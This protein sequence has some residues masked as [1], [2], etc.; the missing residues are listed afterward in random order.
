G[1]VARGEEIQLA[2]LPDHQCNEDRDA[3]DQ[4]RRLGVPLSI[5]IG[6]V[7]DRQ[8]TPEPLCV[9]ANAQ[10]QYQGSERNDLMRPG[11][12]RSHAYSFKP[13]WLAPLVP[14][15]SEKNHR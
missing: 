4:W 3:T 10:G 13:N 6:H 5:G 7:H 12:M 8:L 9:E 1:G 14:L 11:E 15:W 2:E